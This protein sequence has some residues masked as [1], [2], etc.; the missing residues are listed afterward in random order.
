[1]DLTQKRHKLDT[2]RDLMFMVLF[3]GDPLTQNPCNHLASHI[4]DQQPAFHTGGDMLDYLLDQGYITQKDGL[5]VTWY[6]SANKK[7]EMQEALESNVMVLEA[8]VNVEGH[9]TR[10]ETE[11]PIMAHPPDVYSDNTFQEWLDAVLYSSKGIKLDFKSIQAVGPS[12]DILLKKATQVDINRPVWLNADILHGP[13]VPHFISV[14]NASRFFSLIQSKFPN[15]T[16][17][18]GW[19][20]AFTSLLP[21]RTYTKTMIE[22][23]YTKVQN[24]PQRVTFPV[25]A[26]M[27]RQAWPHLSWLLNKSERYSLTL[28]QGKTDPITVEDLLLIR[29]NS[30]PEQIYYDI[31]DPVLSEF[32][33]IAFQQNRKKRFYPGGSLLRYFEPLGVD[34]LYIRWYNNISTLEELTF[35]LEEADGGMLVINVE[36]QKYS[37]GDSILPVVHSNTSYELSVEDCLNKIFISSK[38]WGIY[39]NIQS[40]EAL[41]PT[42]TALSNTYSN[43]ALCNPIWISMAVSHGSFSTPGYI[44]GSKFL[45]AIN[46]TFPFVTIAPRWPSEVLNKGYTEQLISDMLSLCKGCW[47]EISFQLETVAL[48]KSCHTTLQLLESSVSYT[49]TIEHKHEQG[50]LAG[51]IKGL[52]FI[53]TY[54]VLKVYC[55]LPGDYRNSFSNITLTS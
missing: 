10:N 8:D 23:M 11:K 49:V 52:M 1:M 32:K 36:A 14:V 43:N 39:L 47:Q 13:N 16:V 24:L 26:V 40:Q 12:L 18:P 3:S 55:N 50:R 27:V 37:L 20:T 44:E 2:E 7:S 42:L 29:D 25:R 35:V 22:E 38:P 51:G 15:A 21:N 17:S 5:L 41:I 53:Q 31:Y 34:S 6:H 45:K 33:K 9:N 19:K 46:D 4:S 48:G 54:D 28:W 30:N